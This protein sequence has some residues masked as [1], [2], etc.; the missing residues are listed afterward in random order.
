[1]TGE[2]TRDEALSQADGIAYPSEKEMEADRLYFIKKMGWSEEKFK[3]YISRPEKPHTDYPSEIFLY[4]RL[5]NLYRHLNLKFG[6]LT[7]GSD[8]KRTP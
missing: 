7:W 3:D 8:T 4:R 2:I 6:R 5:L 1:M